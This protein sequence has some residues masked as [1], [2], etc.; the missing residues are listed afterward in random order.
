MTDELEKQGDAQ[1][2]D[3]LDRL[4]QDARRDFRLVKDD[5]PINA[6]L[7]RELLEELEAYRCDNPEREGRPIAY[8]RLAEMLGIGHTVLTE[9]IGGTYKGNREAQFRKI[10]QFLSEDRARAGRFNVMGTARIT[11]TN[12]IHGVIKAGIRYR[13]MPVVIGEPGSGKSVHARAFATERTGV[14]LIAADETYND[15]RGVSYLLCEQIPGLRQSMHKS[16]PKRAAAV[17]AWLRKH[18]SA[19]IV[20]DE[21][22]QLTRDGLECLRNLHDK[23]DPAGRRCV[24]V[25]FFGDERFY[26]LIAQGRAGERS[27]IAPQL[28][29]RMYPIF[30]IGEVGAGG[31]DAG[32]FTAADIVKIIRNQ[33][34]RVVTDGGVQWLTRMANVRG[35]GSIGMAI[36]IL[37]MAL[38]ISRRDIVDEDDL[39]AAGRLALG[40]EVIAAIDQQAGGTLLAV[41][42][43]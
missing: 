31:G 19:V 35:Y 41:R 26:R 27:P 1:R 12:Q 38:D 9:L 42:A 30:D 5:Q 8:K 17:L 29:R 18:Q 16:H 3:A 22:Q 24:P 32:P 36:A 39:L 20:V 7:E 43:G 15:A 23:S 33:R 40:P 4:G 21:A 28:T 10:D 13:S 34:V 11:L 25:V 37:R 2:H 14:V 6:E